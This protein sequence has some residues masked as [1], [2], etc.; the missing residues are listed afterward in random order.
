MNDNREARDAMQLAQNAFNQIQSHE[1][2]CA[3]R[4]L[5]AHDKMVSVHKAVD[6]INSNTAKVNMT[7]IATLL[8][9]CGYL[10]SK[11]Y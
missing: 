11:A 5:A 3:E 8:A 1:R 4:W 2:L 10:F 7:V 6:R 9:V